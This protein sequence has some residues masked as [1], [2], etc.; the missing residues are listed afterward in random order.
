MDH[1]TQH[2]R[3][4][5]EARTGLPE[6]RALRFLQRA[7]ERAKGGEAFS[8]RQ[9]TYLERQS[10]DGCRALAYQGCCIIR[11]AEGRCVT[12]YPLPPW[13]HRQQHYRG[14]EKIRNVK[15]YVRLYGDGKGADHEPGQV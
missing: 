4:L 8:G 15:K 12:A 5:A 7:T 13:F 14:K 11:S 3:E 9:R 10:R 1:L 6:K 2:A